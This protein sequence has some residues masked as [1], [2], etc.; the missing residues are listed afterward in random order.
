[1][2]V[3]ETLSLPFTAAE[4]F[5]EVRRQAPG[6]G[7]S[8]VYRTLAT[9]EA[10][11]R[12]RHLITASGRSVF[13]AGDSPVTCLVECPVCG[14]SRQIEDP[15]LAAHAEGHAKR[16]GFALITA[17]WNVTATCPSHRQAPEKP[18]H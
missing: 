1:M 11:A 16:A 7:R 17:H 6:I 14:H 9:L 10:Q 5:S 4:L 13:A 12:L 2:A 15:E 18:G 8:T 3:V